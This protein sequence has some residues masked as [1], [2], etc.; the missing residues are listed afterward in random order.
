ML[1]DNHKIFESV[2]IDSYLKR[3]VNAAKEVCRQ[4]HHTPRFFYQSKYLIYNTESYAEKFAKDLFSKYI[5]I[6]RGKLYIKCLM[7]I[8]EQSVGQSYNDIWNNILRPLGKPKGHDKDL[9]AG[10]E[11][12]GLTTIVGYGK[13]KAPLYGITSLGKEVLNAV[14]ANEAAYRVLRHFMVDPDEYAMKIINE[15]LLGTGESWNDLTPETVINFLKETFDSNSSIQKIG[16]HFYWINKF[17]NAYNE[18]QDFRD[19]IRKPE[20][21]AFI[22]RI[23]LENE[24]AKRFQKKLAKIDVRLD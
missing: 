11:L 4:S 6:T 9:I 2:A 3:Y 7:F 18:S 24:P 13:Y 14:N 19:L 10:M 23:A 8:N 22:S 5:R 12:N 15:D 17:I 21:T 16:S 20:I 1:K